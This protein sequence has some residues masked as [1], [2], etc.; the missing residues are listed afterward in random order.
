MTSDQSLATG[1]IGNS[2]AEAIA[3]RSDRIAKEK[4]R[5]GYDVPAFLNAIVDL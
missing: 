2:S 1:K 4:R 3:R 5:N